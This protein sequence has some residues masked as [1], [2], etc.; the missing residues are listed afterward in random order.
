MPGCCFSLKIMLTMFVAIHFC[1]APYA[2]FDRIHL[3]IR[4]YGTQIGLFDDNNIGF[5]HKDWTILY[6]CHDVYLM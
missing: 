4:Y 2:V 1:R 6:L 3:V 5:D